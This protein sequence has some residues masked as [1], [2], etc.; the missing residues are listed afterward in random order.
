MKSLDPVR[1]KFS[2]IT[3]PSSIL[4]QLKIF[5]N[6]NISYSLIRTHTCAYQRIRNVSF[7]GD[8]ELLENTKKHLNEKVGMKWVECF[9]ESNMNIEFSKNTLA[10]K[11][12]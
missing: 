5:R 4:L 2:F 1:A 11:I 9:Y 6:T 10:A 3:I 7:A 8:F 12:S